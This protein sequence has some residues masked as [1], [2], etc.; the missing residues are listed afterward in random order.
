MILQSLEHSQRY[1]TLHRHFAKGF[2]FLQQTDIATLDDGRYEIIG[3]ELFALVMRLHGKAKAEAKV[4]AHRK[5]IDI[6]FII[7]GQEQMGWKPHTDEAKV[8]EPYVAERD[9]ELYEPDGLHWLSVKSNQFAIFFPD[10]IHAPG[11]G[12]GAIHKVVLKVKV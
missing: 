11:V 9:V 5:H 4:E 1:A 6:Q 8:F 10:D 3:D 2:E 7:S 12:D